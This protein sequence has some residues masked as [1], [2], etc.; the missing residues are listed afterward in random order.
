MRN[1]MLMENYQRQ[2]IQFALEQQALLFG[3][4]TL[5]SQRLSPYFFNSGCF[6][7]GLAIARL[8]Q[9]YADAIVGAQVEFDML[10]GPAYKGI[11]LVT[12][13]AIA[14]AERYNLNKPFA[15]NRK[16]VKD[17]GEGKLLVGAPLAGKVLTIDDVITAGK[18]VKE[19]HEIISGANA[20]W[21]GEVILFD[22]CEKGLDTELSA[23]EQAELNYNAPII[24]VASVKEL[25]D[26][27]QET[28]MQAEFERIK[29]YQARYGCDSAVLA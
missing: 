4:Y 18:T 2:F 7:N 19:A 9:F 1:P 29:S 25:L 16:E 22:R 12:A 26:Y 28:G 27:L 5:K 15:Y 13:V 17:H 11:P 14:L 6:D 23:V 21:V 10:F 24:K 8:G 3:E 20:Q